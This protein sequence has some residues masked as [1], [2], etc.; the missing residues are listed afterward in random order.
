MTKTSEIENFPGLEHGVQGVGLI[1]RMTEQAQRFG[2]RFD[3]GT[4][5]AVD[6]SVRPFQLKTTSGETIQTKSLIIATG[7][8]PKKLGV[9]GE[10]EFW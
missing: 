4:I 8:S 6:L 7:A 5:D 3:F 2:A 10:E 9:K 1:E